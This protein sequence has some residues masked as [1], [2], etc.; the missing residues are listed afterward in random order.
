VR[1]IFWA[2]VGL[3]FLCGCTAFQEKVEGM[4]V[5]MG[6]CHSPYTDW[7]NRVE[8]DGT[9]DA[10]ASADA[11]LQCLR[12]NGVKGPIALVTR[13]VFGATPPPRLRPPGE[14]R[15]DLDVNSLDLFAAHY[16]P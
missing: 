16:T 9:H 10:E 4:Q 5:T 15:R 12:R 3:S 6:A 1:L 14:Q 13:N 7:R 11:L 2:L 8:I